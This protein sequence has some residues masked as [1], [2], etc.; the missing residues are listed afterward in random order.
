MYGGTAGQVSIA[1]TDGGLSPR[2]RGN[3]SVGRDVELVVRSIPACTGEPRSGLARARTVKVYPRV[4]GGTLRWGRLCS[5]IAG[6]SPRVR[7]NHVRQV[8]TCGPPSVYPRV[9]GGTR[10]TG[11]AASWRPGLSPRVRGN[12][13]DHLSRRVCTQGLSPRVRGNLSVRPCWPMRMVYPRVYGGTPSSTVPV[14]LQPSGL[15]PRVRGNLPQDGG[16][17]RS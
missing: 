3:Q 6:L 9:Y 13:S 8:Q 4:Y 14:R 12:L 16:S 1:A 2:V 11:P 7:G 15:S 5:F 10:Q 17:R